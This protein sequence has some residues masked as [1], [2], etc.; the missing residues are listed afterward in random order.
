MLLGVASSVA[1][2][3]AVLGAAASAADR[4]YARPLAIS[5]ASRVLQ[6]RLQPADQPQRPEARATLPWYL[7][8]HWQTNLADP[9]DLGAHR[10]LRMTW[11][12]GDELEQIDVSAA[13]FGFFRVLSTPP[14]LGRVIDSADEQKRAQVAVLSH[15]FWTSRFGASGD[16]IGRSIRLDQSDFTVVGIMPSTFSI[17]QSA[18]AWI[19][20]GS[21][22]TPSAAAVW[23]SQF[24]FDAVARSP[25]ARSIGL[26]EQQFQAGLRQLADAHPE[27]RQW[28]P[29]VV[30]LVDTMFLPYRTPAL[31]L[32]FGAAVLA[33]LASANVVHLMNART[34]AQEHLLRVRLAIGSSPGRIIATTVAEHAVLVLSAALIG[35]FGAYVLF[36]VARPYLA[37]AI[38]DLGSLSASWAAVG[39]A[40]FLA[41]LVP[42]LGATIGTYRIVR[43]VSKRPLHALEHRLRGPRVVL[44]GQSAAAMTLLAVALSATAS[45]TALERENRFFERSEVMLAHVRLPRFRY[46]EP[47][48]W[49]AYATRLLDRLELNGYRSVA[50]ANSAPFASGV[51]GTIEIDGQRLDPPPV[52]HQTGVSE[53]YFETLGIPLAQGYSPL[54]RHDTAALDIVVNEAMKRDVLGDRPVVDTWLTFA[55]GDLRGRIV[56]VSA[57]VRQRELR[58]KAMPQLYYPIEASPTRNLYVFAARGSSRQQG[59]L[60]AFRRSIASV[61]SAVPIEFALDLGEYTGQSIS[62][63]RAFA[64]LTSLITFAVLIVAATGIYSSVALAAQQ[65]RRDL[66]VRLALGSTFARLLLQLVRFTA[67]VA[68][69]GILLG[70]LVVYV[71]NDLLAAFV[72]QWSPS[73][74]MILVTAT[75]ILVIA[76]MLAMLRPLILLGKL[77]VSAALHGNL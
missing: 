36:E 45:I 60:A 64:F 18:S 25:E 53:S 42:L 48:L 73:T 39:A 19:P 29:S 30:R 3:T 55:G 26:L 24:A 13:S 63:E 66:V 54:A 67:I 34:L 15:S 57:D 37:S 17:P 10:L 46:P 28:S 22:L 20:I 43:A 56:N 58:E 76:V 12:T 51:V 74:P 44:I 4:I 41:A 40:V 33:L 69:A 21:H 1:A 49:Q 70:V 75:L 31:F 11:D 6:I 77:D 52:S 72:Y 65:R 7:V 14:I 5:D 2:T 47:H 32:A 9:L 16:V 27:L 61:D 68:F 59:D 23:E 8:R 50:V 38:P 35:A 62:F 71:L